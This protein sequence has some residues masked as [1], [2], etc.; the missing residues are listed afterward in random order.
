MPR[1]L[2]ASFSPAAQSPKYCP[3]A[4]HLIVASAS[5]SMRLATSG[6]GGVLD[7]HAD[8]PRSCCRRSVFAMPRSRNDACIIFANSVSRS[9]FGPLVAQPAIT[10]AAARPRKTCL[11]LTGMAST[12]S[13]LEGRRDRFRA[14]GVD[15]HVDRQGDGHVG[16]ELGKREALE[17]Q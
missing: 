13:A 11:A 9:A 12:P 3:P 14:L 1:P 6:E 2:S 5:A 15:A 16:P 17:P 7:E 10:A 4:G 8:W